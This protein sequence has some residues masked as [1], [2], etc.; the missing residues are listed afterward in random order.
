MRKSNYFRPECIDS[1]IAPPEDEYFGPMKMC[2]VYAFHHFLR[3]VATRM[4]NQ[5]KG[6]WNQSNIFKETYF[7]PNN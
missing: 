1:C 4:V 7:C 6:S 3:A 2:P 5:N